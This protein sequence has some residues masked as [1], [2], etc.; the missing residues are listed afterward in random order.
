[1][2]RY[3]VLDGFNYA[4]FDLASLITNSSTDTPR[5]QLE[6]EITDGDKSVASTTVVQI[7]YEGNSMSGTIDCE[8]GMLNAITSST[9]VTGRQPSLPDW[10]FDG[11]ILGIQGG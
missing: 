10:S 5:T 8:N 11:A 9:E 2:G 6:G 7:T 1:M 4:L 3:F